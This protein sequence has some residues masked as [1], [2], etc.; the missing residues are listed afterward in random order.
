MSK[1][2]VSEL[3]CDDVDYDDKHSQESYLHIED[4]IS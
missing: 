1:W 2:D 3:S 4:Y